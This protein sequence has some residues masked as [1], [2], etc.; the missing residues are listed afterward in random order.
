MCRHL[1]GT[2]VFGAKIFFT[3]DCSLPGGCLLVSALNVIQGSFHGVPRIPGRLLPQPVDV[4]EERNVFILFQCHTPFGSQLI[5][6]LKTLLTILIYKILF[7]KYLC[8][9]TQNSYSYKYDTIQM[10]DLENK[11]QMSPNLVF[12]LVQILQRLPAISM[13]AN[14]GLAFLSGLGG[15]ESGV[16]EHLAEPDFLHDFRVGIRIAGQGILVGHNEYLG[17]AVLLLLL[18]AS[19]Q[20]HDPAHVILQEPLEGLTPVHAELNSAPAQNE[21][22]HTGVATL[23]DDEG[24]GLCLHLLQL[25]APECSI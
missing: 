18:V 2:A 13:E 3:V 25:L 20:S 1:L 19:H 24:P 14:K 22:L 23:G 10:T 7:V 5:W 21:H 9:K 8:Y 17:D 16:H 15:P 11:E 6:A 12:V 4:T